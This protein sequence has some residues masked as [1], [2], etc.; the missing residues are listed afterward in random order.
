MIEDN[1]ITLLIPAKNE[2]VETEEIDLDEKID[3]NATFNN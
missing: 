3:F 1:E 2:T